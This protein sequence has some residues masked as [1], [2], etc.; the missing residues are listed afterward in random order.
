VSLGEELYRDI[1]L[2]HANNPSRRGSLEKCTHSHVGLNPLCGDEIELQL[3]VENGVISDI[4]FRGEGCSI[5]QA[6]ASMLTEEVVGK[7]VEE[8]GQL[9]EIFKDWMKDRAKAEPAG[10]IGD[11]EALSGV[12]SYP[13]RIKCALLPWTTMHE[14]LR[15]DEGASS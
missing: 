15:A 6:S 8:A 5:S 4:R 14:A 7:T 1:I 3:L 11:L 13:V 10:P 2:E 9:T 12:R